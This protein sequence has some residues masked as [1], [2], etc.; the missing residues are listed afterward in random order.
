[1]A[2]AASPEKTG[3]GRASGGAGAL[4]WWGGLGSGALIVMSPA[5]AT[6]LVVLL[7]P[8]LLLAMLPEEGQSGRIVR[9][10]LAFG[11][12]ASL[13]PLRALWDSG[14]TLADALSLARQPTTLFPAW[15]AIG[16]GWLIAEL[17]SMLLRL[18]SEMAAAA[19]RR[20]LAANLTALE[21]EWGTL[22][23]PESST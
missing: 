10:S 15:I 19:Q 17:A 6:M 18:V 20:A 16:A 21:E 5:S 13:H 7:C 2:K 1:M 9:A 23:P 22:L 4:L 14:A 12:A 11:V 3:A 8:I